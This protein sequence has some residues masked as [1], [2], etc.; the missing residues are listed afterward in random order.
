VSLTQFRNK[1]HY[2]PAASA[3]YLQKAF[4]V[5]KR[6]DIAGDVCPIPP[7]HQLYGEVK[8]R[9]QEIERETVHCSSMP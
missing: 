2:L 3:I 7:T 6:E 4:G 5:E 9:I 8:E 1:H